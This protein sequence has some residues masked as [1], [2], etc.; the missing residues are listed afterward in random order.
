V[1]RHQ[2]AE[3]M[4]RELHISGPYSPIVASRLMAAADAMLALMETAAVVGQGGAI[5]PGKGAILPVGTKLWKWR[6]PA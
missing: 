2:I 1:T 4:A 5:L 3:A 6:S